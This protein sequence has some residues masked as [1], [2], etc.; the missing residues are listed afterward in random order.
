MKG[1]VQHR[2]PQPSPVPAVEETA[3]LEWACTATKENAKLFHSDSS[4]VLTYLLSL[5]AAPLSAM[6]K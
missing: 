3:T 6:T 5:P 4:G 1:Q 2:L